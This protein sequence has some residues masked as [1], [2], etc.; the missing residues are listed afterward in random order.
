[1]GQ[2]V[3]A[4]GMPYNMGFIQLGAFAWSCSFSYNIFLYTNIY[5]S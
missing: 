5:H 1:M 2:E 3:Y 4:R